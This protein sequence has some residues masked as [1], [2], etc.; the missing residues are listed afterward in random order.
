MSHKNI[1]EKPF[2]GLKN[3]FPGN[4]T[5]PD[6]M[7]FIYSLIEQNSELAARLEQADSRLKL[8]EELVR[9]AARKLDITRAESQII[10]DEAYQTAAKVTQ[11]KLSS[12]T[13]QAQ[14]IVKEAEAV[15]SRAEVESNRMISEARQLAE[16]AK[17]QAHEIVNS[18]AAQADSTRAL[19]KQE[20]DKILVDTTKI[21]EEQALHIR[22]EAAKMLEN[23][24]GL[25]HS[26]PVEKFEQIHNR[27]HSVQDVVG[28][29]Q[30]EATLVQGPGSE[31]KKPVF[32]EGAIELLIKPPITTN[33][34][35]G[36]L[37]HLKQ[38]RGI[39]IVELKKSSDHGVCVKLL[40]RSRV[41][42]LNILK[43]APE[44]EEV[45]PALRKD[46]NKATSRQTAE[47]AAARSISVTMRQ[48]TPWYRSHKLVT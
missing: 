27:L 39:G 43:E 46:G 35:S 40:V 13:Q 30:V 38:I 10:I 26:E 17:K 32:Y 20:A 22:N 16:A 48:L 5:D 1:M 8:A 14:Q 33:N 24:K 37:T 6:T 29:K 9:E 47:A 4:G 31:E 3:E 7:H 15:K 12:A 34:V 2:G 44:V 25:I 42:L 19:A 28:Q 18:A 23:S 41:P 21:A 36:L 11:E 45:Y